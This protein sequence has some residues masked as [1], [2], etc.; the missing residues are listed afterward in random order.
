MTPFGIPQCN[1][2]NSGV[3]NNVDTLERKK[4]SL[5]CSSIV[6]YSSSLYLAF[7]LKFYNTLST[8]V[9]HS[10]SRINGR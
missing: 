10:P 6:L 4:V 8:R 9:A 2:I 7:V 3:E 1:P 5:Y